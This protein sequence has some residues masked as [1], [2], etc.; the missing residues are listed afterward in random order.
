MAF[1]LPSP[2]DSDG[3]EGWGW[4]HEQ[5]RQGQDRSGVGSGSGSGGVSFRVGRAGWAQNLEADTIGKD[6][7]EEY[8]CI[9]VSASYSRHVPIPRRA[10]SIP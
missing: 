10:P 3:H 6:A 9:Q 1:G 4:V 2:H 8:R 7:A 5:G